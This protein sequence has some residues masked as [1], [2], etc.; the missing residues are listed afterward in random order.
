M[1][2]ISKPV[3]LKNSE[4]L[5][6]AEGKI[7]NFQLVQC[8]TKVVGDT[9]KCIQLDRD[10]WRIYLTPKEGRDKLLQQGKDVDDQHISVYDSNPYSTGLEA[11]DDR[12]LKITICGVPL[13]VDDS[14]VFEMLSKLKVPPTNTNVLWKFRNPETKKMTSIL[15]GN[16]FLYIEPIPLNTYLTRNVYC[17]DWNVNSFTR[18]SMLINR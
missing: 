18:T 3:Y 16:R 17:A 6:P 1:S 2:Q 13:S 12:S 7:T 5:A 14:A 10:L 4:I 15:S 8:V 11:P 9:V